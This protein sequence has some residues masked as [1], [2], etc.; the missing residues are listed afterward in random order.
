MA[1]S[2]GTDFG[3]FGFIS[4]HRTISGQ[5]V[6]RYSCDTSFPSFYC[7]SVCLEAIIAFYTVYGNCVYFRPV[8]GYSFTVSSG[9][10]S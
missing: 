7:T 4:G 9:D 10:D 3:F 8:D 6:C 2:V 1:N 5:V